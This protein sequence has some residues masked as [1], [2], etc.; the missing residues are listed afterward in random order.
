M[1]FDS[2]ARERN[3]IVHENALVLAMQGR[4]ANA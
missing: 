3:R 2:L 4:N 1:A